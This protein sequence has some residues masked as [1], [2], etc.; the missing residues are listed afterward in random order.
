M[1]ELDIDI[2][3]RLG[4]QNKNAGASLRSPVGCR[5]RKP[6]DARVA[7]VVAGTDVGV[8]GGLFVKDLGS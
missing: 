5:C 8:S 6:G 3:Y 4:P 1:A 7:T 2:Y